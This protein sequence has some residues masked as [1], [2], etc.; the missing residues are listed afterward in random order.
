V[1]HVGEEL[2]LERRRLFE[3]D[4]L[5]PQYS[6]WCA[7]SAVA[8][9]RALALVGRDLQLRVEP[10]LRAPRAG[11]P[12]RDHRSQLA[13]RQDLAG[14][15]LDRHRPWPVRGSLRPIPP[16]RRWSALT[17]MPAMNDEK[18]ASLACTQRCRW[19]WPWPE[20]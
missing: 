7:I 8:A 4:R 12:D 1:R 11:P 5:A 18:C 19:R 10:G 20:S 2:G 3:L 16:T 9:D 15:R 14:N 6:F 13:A 17:S